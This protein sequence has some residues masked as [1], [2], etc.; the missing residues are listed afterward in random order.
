MVTFSVKNQT[1]GKP[2]FDTPCWW[3]VWFQLTN[4]FIF[5]HLQSGLLSTLRLPVDILNH[6][7]KLE[8]TQDVMLGTMTF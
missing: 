8:E 6:I 1:T 5:D 4:I 3:W 2:Y 7:R